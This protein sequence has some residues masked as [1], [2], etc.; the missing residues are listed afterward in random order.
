[1]LGAGECVIAFLCNAFFLT[2]I[3][4]HARVREG[5]LFD[6]GGDDMNI[7]VNIP[8][9]ATAD[10]ASAGP[11]PA[12]ALLEAFA[13]DGYRAGR[14]SEAGVR[15]LLGFETRD[16]V[17][18]FLKEHGA[19]M[20]YTMEEIEQDTAVALDVALRARAERNPNPSR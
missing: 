20:H 19:F 8:D 7:T 11:D 10:L 15:R 12:R 5:A 16:E 18:G 13:L 6:L 1:V 4:L 17:D 2:A 3:L 14:L 9:S